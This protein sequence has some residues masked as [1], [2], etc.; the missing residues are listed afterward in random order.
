LL[1]V[2]GEF[3]EAKEDWVRQ[4]GHRQGNNIL[5]QLTCSVLADAAQNFF[6]ELALGLRVGVTVVPKSTGELSL[7]TGVGVCIIRMGSEMVSECDVLL[8]RVIAGWTDIKVMWEIVGRDSEGLPTGNAQIAL[9]LISEG[10][11]SGDDDRKVGGGF[12]E[13]VDVNNRFGRQSRNRS[14]PDVFNGGRRPLKQ[15]SDP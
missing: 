10:S 1:T 4:G 7:Q 12:Q 11:Q 15:G 3:E 5:V 14:A 9:V 13:H 6:H 8:I 2:R